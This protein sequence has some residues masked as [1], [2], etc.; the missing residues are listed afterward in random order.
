MV[1]S[2][3]M[4]PGDQVQATEFDRRHLYPLKHLWPLGFF[5]STDRKGQTGG[6]AIFQPHS[7]PFRFPVCLGQWTCS[8]LPRE[9]WS[10]LIQCLIQSGS[11]RPGTVVSF[12]WRGSFVRCRPRTCLMEGPADSERP[13]FTGRSEDFLLLSLRWEH[14]T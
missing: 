6:F 14:Q 13:S 1:F 12:C 2:N 7:Q 11:N 3:H 10:Y 5:V 9:W 8:C 4:G